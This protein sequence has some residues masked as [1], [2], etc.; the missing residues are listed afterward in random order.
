MCEQ[1]SQWA[2]KYQSLED[3]QH[4]PPLYLEPWTETCVCLEG[5]LD[6]SREFLPS[7][8]QVVQ[9]LSDKLWLNDSEMYKK[10]EQ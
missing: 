3:K 8:E 5:L 6:Y 9:T 1:G 7:E 10:I 4:S 2:W